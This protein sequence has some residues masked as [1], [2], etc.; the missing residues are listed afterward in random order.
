MLTVAHCVV[1]G[2]VCLWVGVCVCLCVGGSQ[3][4]RIMLE[5]RAC[6]DPHQTG[7]VAKGSDHIQ[8]LAESA[9]RRS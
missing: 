7:F 2:P 9:H 5:F 8:T 6:I 1:I 3:H 4:G